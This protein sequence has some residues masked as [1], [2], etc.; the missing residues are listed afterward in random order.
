MS[1][2]LELQSLSGVRPLYAFA[3]VVVG[4][5]VVGFQISTL[6]RQDVPR[7][8]AVAAA[9]QGFREPNRLRLEDRHG[10]VL[11]RSQR[12]YML[13]AS[14]FNLWLRHTPERLLGD[15][16]QL[17]SSEP[18][19]LWR[20]LAP[21]SEDGL[22]HVSRWP[23]THAEALAL[24]DWIE[25]GGPRA[26]DSSAQ[27]P[28]PGFG[29]ER[30]SPSPEQHSG[31]L[32]GL[33]G[34]FFQLVFDPWAALSEATREAAWPALAERRGAAQ[35]W[36]QRLCLQ[37]YGLLTGPMERER[38]WVLAESQRRA[39]GLDPQA[40]VFPAEVPPVWKLEL[41]PSSGLR[42]LE[43]HV[44]ELVVERTADVGPRLVHK[45]TKV[46]WVFEGLCPSRYVALAKF[47]E[48]AK[49][50]AL[51]AFLEREQMSSYELW[52][53][54]TAQRRYPTSLEPLAADGERPGPVGRYGWYE[55]RGADGQAEL[56]YG[57]QEGLE[58]LA[59][60][61]LA[62]LERE[63][64]AESGD[65]LA[66]IGRPESLALS[67]RNPRA[68]WQRSTLE[69]ARPAQAPALVR[70]TLDLELSRR[71]HELLSA[72]V[73]Q[74]QVGLGMAVVLDL[75]TRDILALEWVDP[76]EFHAF[77]PLVH[78][79]T[80][81][82]TFKVVTMAAALE[83]GHVRP[84]EVFEL[85]YQGHFTIWAGEPGQSR[86]RT[87]REAEGFAKG[88]NTAAM[89]LARSSNEGMVKIGLRVPVERWKSFTAELG[90]GRPALPGLLADWMANPRG[91][92]G[93]APNDGKEWARLR[94]HASVSFG[95]SI[96]T[97]LLQHA[98]ALASLTGGGQFL[99]LNLLR[100]VELSGQRYAPR[101]PEPRR[102]I[103]ERTSQQLRTMMRLGAEEGTA[104]RVPRPRGLDLMT[105]TGT[106]Q[107]LFG[108]VCWHNFGRAWQ[109]A[110]ERGEP[111]ESG[112]V[113]KQL[114]GQFRSNRPCY[115]SSMVAVGRAPG[116]ER[117]I[118]VLVVADDPHGPK[119]FGSEV[120]G[121]TAVQIL[122]AALG[123]EPPREN[124]APRAA[125]GLVLSDSPI[126][127]IDSEPWAVTPARA[128]TPWPE[129]EGR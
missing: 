125:A 72:M 18:A 1:P 58:A 55:A 67:V 98:Q 19:A 20:E 108:D 56:R 75:A 117:E 70:T 5:V 60:R 77:A 122:C 52:L 85:S 7:R 39:G 10:R 40:L 91:Q 27:G 109:R 129:G 35:A 32:A 62:D 92:I 26:A 48:P 113:H 4:L 61:A 31:L 71:V 76:F 110:R 36:V 3:L 46:E 69:S 49:V 124:A 30:A 33:E 78:Q 83:G 88:P 81:G 43:S 102:V 93:E 44:A 126:Q 116:S 22:V 100:E 64:G 12:G 120:A 51:R 50:D 79:F 80:P 84:E 94:S 17:L 59:E 114:R 107:K 106:T 128:E 37:L 87:I 11:A 21:L 65:S 53:A 29:L 23:L 74:H 112:R 25:A 38:A 68:G 127:A 99:P 24:S 28:L 41:E 115:V 96:S 105:K 66:G 54:N 34:P 16:A 42:G 97:N 103:S 90:Y 57:P 86:R 63:L 118:L 47:V 119:R 104:K 73:E 121:P 9:D 89:C 82:S 123:F 101:P 6:A 45:D 8:G 13:E 14:P 2:R 95:D 15:L 111:F